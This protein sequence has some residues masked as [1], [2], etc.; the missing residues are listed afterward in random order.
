MQLRPNEWEWAVEKKQ[1]EYNPNRLIRFLMNSAKMSTIGERMESGYYWNKRE[2]LNWKH[3]NRFDENIKHFLLTNQPTNWQKKKCVNKTVDNL[4]TN[5]DSLF[6]FYGCVW[7]ATIQFENRQQAATITATTRCRDQQITPMEKKNAQS[8][9]NI[10]WNIFG[11]EYENR[12]E[13]VCERAW[14][15]QLISNIHCVSQAK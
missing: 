15:R 14:V 7:N 6:S 12:I 9:I 4:L 1:I 5:V 3:E 11:T 8:P 10:K 13:Q 2:Q